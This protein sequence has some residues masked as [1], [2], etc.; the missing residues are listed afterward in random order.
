[1]R[2]LFADLGKTARVPMLWIYA[3]NDMYFGPDLPREWFKAFEQEGGVGRFIELPPQGDDG[4]LT[5]SRSPS[6]WKPLVLDFLRA[7]GFKV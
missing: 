3:E 1:L 7:R 6:V 4:H 2:R 5:F